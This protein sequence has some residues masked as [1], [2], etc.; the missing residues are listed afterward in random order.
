MAGSCEA[1]ILAAI[2]KDGKITDRWARIP[3]PVKE[4][5]KLPSG[6]VVMAAAAKHLTSI[7][8]ELGGK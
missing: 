1:W 5:R 3:E 8:L 2:E 7:T 4:T 6:K